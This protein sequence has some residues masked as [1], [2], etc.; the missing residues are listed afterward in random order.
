M[1]ERWM[2]TI[3]SLLC[4]VASSTLFICLSAI[5]KLR[6]NS[7]TTNDNKTAVYMTFM[8]ILLHTINAILDPIGFYFYAISPNETMNIT[9]Y[10][11]WSAT[12]TLSKL[13][14]Y[15][16]YIYRLFLTFKGTPYSYSHT[17]YCP[18][19]LLW[20]LQCAVMIFYISVRSSFDEDTVL[21]L[22]AST[23]FV[24]FDFILIIVVMLLFIIPI[25]K[26][27][28]SLK[29]NAENIM[30]PNL[31]NMAANTF[32]I[33]TDQL[34]NE[35]EKNLSHQNVDSMDFAIHSKTYQEKKR[36]DEIVSLSTSDFNFGHEMMKFKTRDTL[37]TYNSTI[38]SE[39]Y[40]S[41]EIVTKKNPKWNLKQQILLGFA[42]RLGLLAAIA[43]ISSFLYQITWIISVSTHHERTRIYWFTYTWNIDTLINTICLFLSFKFTNDVYERVCIELCQWHQS[44][45]KCVG[46][47]L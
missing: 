12:W 19:S 20:I 24:I 36:N 29:K 45:M 13:S 44:C 33:D 30:I 40:G 22:I 15:L 6:C 14:L 42:T 9:I 31:F 18:I 28:K 1:A 16:I 3:F 26:L 23:I 25:S 39:R 5:Y 46:S 7:N 38:R 21:A 10:N 4:I 34:L 2:F 47:L 37:S 41:M 32:D 11:A 35:N 43:L 8:C 27:I 17:V